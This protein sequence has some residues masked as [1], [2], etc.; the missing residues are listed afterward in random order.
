[1]KYQYN[2]NYSLKSPFISISA[3]VNVKHVKPIY[4][5][6]LQNIFNIDNVSMVYWV[7]IKYGILL[8]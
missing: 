2:R 5:Y 8:I 7:L 4:T 1:M 6:I 3:D